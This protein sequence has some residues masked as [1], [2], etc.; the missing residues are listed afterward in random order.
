MDNTDRIDRYLTGTMDPAEKQAFEAEM[1]ADAQLAEDLTLQRDMGAFL[2]RREHRNAL[3]AQLRDIGRAHFQPEKKE[4]KT[5]SISRRRILWIGAMA[6]AA[7]LALFLL[8]PLL[9]PPS[10]FDQYA[11]YPALALAQKSSAGPADW[12]AAEQAFNSEDYTTAEPVLEQYLAA[13][14]TDM[15]AQL[16]LG[17]CKMELDK[18]TEARQIFGALAQSGESFKDYAQWYLALSY[19]KSGDTAATQKT[20]D[21]IPDS[22]PF[23]KKAKELAARL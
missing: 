23:Y 13:Y 4:A 10:L 14:P 16:Y 12:S 17:I 19:L 3:Q 20:L 21:E 9:F 11:E 18:H 6:A 7:G 22:S 5:V 8:R 2:R 1:A 15:Q